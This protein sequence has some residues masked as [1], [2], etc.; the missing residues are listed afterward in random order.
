MNEVKIS[1]LTPVYNTEKYIAAAI[2]SVLNQTFTDFELL[3]INDGSTDNSMEIVRR[4]TDPRIVVFN[5]PNLGVAAALNKGLQLA[6]GEFIARFDSD[7]I[8]Y[9]ERLAQQYDFMKAHPDYVLIGSDADYMDE[10]GEVIYYYKTPSHT[11]DEI[12][13]VILKKCP[14]IHSTVFY[15]TKV[16]IDLGG[17]DVKAHT[18]EDYLLWTKFIKKGKVLNF[19]RPLIAVRMNPH[20]VTIDERRRGQ[21]FLSLRKQILIRGNEISDNEERELSQALSNVSKSIYKHYSYHLLLA[22]KFLWNNHQPSKARQ[23]IRKALSYKP[24]SFLGW[25]LYILSL[26]PGKLVLKIYR[27]SKKL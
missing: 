10:T 20:S 23:N 17:Y 12:H 9:P 5:Q 2:T 3:I 21:K 27:T 22:K 26:L 18:F 13:D 6:K 24:I 4:F 19:N 8:C 1:V 15:K 16:A 7:D 11:S 25:G 14:F